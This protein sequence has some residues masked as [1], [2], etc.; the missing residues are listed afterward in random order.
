MLHMHEKQG[1]GGG[2]ALKYIY[3]ALHYVH[4]QWQI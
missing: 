4:T 1:G 3:T 2:G